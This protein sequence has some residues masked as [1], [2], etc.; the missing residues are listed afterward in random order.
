MPITP[1]NTEK[2]MTRA[3]PIDEG[4]FLKTDGIARANIMIIFVA[5]P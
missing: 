3:R 5:V 2:L 1:V 4:Y